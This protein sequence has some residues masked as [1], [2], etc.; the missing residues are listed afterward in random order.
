[1][2][3]L[4]QPL[5]PYQ[6]EGVAHLVRAG[7]AVL[8]DDMGLG[9]TV[10]TI[11]ACEVLRRRGEA[12]RILVV[13]P[14]SLK[15]QWAGGIARYAGAQAVVIVGGA[16]ARRAAFASDAPY[17]VL[18]YE[19]TWRDLRLKNL[20]ADV[21]VLDEAQRA[22]NF[23]TKTAATLKSIPSR[24][25]FVLTGTPVENRLDDLY[26]IL[27]LADADVLGPLWKFNLDF[28]ERADDAKG[29][30][31]GYRNLAALRRTI[32]PVCSG[33][34]RRPCSRSSLR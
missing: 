21:L 13:C 10:Q 5:F 6:R 14:A 28:H 30:I 24:F 12:K 16:D 7:R 32:A 4:A 34:Q 2:D 1:M 26:G 18:N 8:A 25:L 27:Q 9:K 29:K 19:L 17:V 33:G 22:K 3:V 11:A 31:V 23:R 20:E 15:A